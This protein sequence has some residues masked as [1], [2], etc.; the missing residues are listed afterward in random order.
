[1]GSTSIEA[2]GRPRTSWGVGVSGIALLWLALI[3]AS[4][5]G[6]IFFQVAL[7]RE[8]PGWLDVV[9]FA[10][11]AALLVLSVAVDAW[12]PLRR[13]FLA[14]IAWGVGGVIVGHL[15]AL[16]T[17]GR[18]ASMFANTLLRLIPCALL[19]LTLLG[20]GLVR[21]DVFL[22][23]G[24]MSAVARLPWGT[25]SWSR[26]GPALIVI[27]AV[28]L[29]IQLTLTVHPDARLLGR[30]LAALPLAVAFAAVNAAQEE[31]SYRAVFLVHL[32][33]A[34]GASQALLVTSLLFGLAHWYGHPGGPSG[35]LLAGFAG[36]LWGKSMIETRGSAWAWLIH[37]FQ[38]VVIF[39]FL[40]A[41]GG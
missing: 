12:R 32:V 4:D 24:D 22:T 7:R 19:A 28:G 38:D 25:V 20:T 8:P 3:P 37:A 6:Q 36:Y 5:A 35:V 27:L 15:A 31:F 11:L 18:E 1:M 29:S 34:V 17:L 23:R 40:V 30:A 14:L 26:L 2:V 39:A 21:K 10:M 41:A 33:P 16:M 13:W 9:D